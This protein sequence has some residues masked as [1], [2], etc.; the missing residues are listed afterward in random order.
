MA[1][2]V[3]A[4]ALREEPGAPPSPEPQSL[5]DVLATSLRA[6]SDARLV[7]FAVI[8]AGL[9]A[10]VLL[11]RGGALWILSLPCFALAAAG[12]WGI[13]DREVRD[14]AGDATPRTRTLR[15]VRAA[16]GVIGAAAALVFTLAIL[17]LMFANWIS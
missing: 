2:L 10:A 9:G 16:V 8:G 5:R 11:I 3:S 14:T 4:D 15:A 1:R 13:T 7:T 17:M 12:G 6:K